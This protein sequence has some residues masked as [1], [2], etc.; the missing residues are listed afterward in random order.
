MSLPESKTQKEFIKCFKF[1]ISVKKKKQQQ[2]QLY[3]Y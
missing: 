1:L 3:M 2:L